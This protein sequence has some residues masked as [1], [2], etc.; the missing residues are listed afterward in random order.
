MLQ[1]NKATKLKEVIGTSIEE[2]IANIE[3]QNTPLKFF[4]AHIGAIESTLA[5]S[6]CHSMIREI[7]W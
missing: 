3:M 6:Y 7:H 5:M 4:Q 1:P 2:R